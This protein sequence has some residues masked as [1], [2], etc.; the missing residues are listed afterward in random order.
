MYDDVHYLLVRL[1]ESWSRF[2]LQT[3]DQGSNMHRSTILQSTCAD[4][5]VYSGENVIEVGVGGGWSGSLGEGEEGK[6]G[7]QRKRGIVCV[8]V[9]VPTSAYLPT[10]L[11]ACLITYLSRWTAYM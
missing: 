6:G 9:C 2:H 5:F 3:L 7:K 1:L 11:P 4:A 10:C 8:S